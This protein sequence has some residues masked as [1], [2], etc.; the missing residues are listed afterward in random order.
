MT[1]AN[2]VREA[3]KDRRLRA[4]LDAIARQRRSVQGGALCGA[5]WVVRI[6]ATGEAEIRDHWGAV[7]VRVCKSEAEADLWLAAQ[8]KDGSGI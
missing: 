3:E 8:R 1:T 2:E 6:L 7:D 4:K 5:R